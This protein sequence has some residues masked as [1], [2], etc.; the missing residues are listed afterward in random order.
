M[1][2]AYCRGSRKRPDGSAHKFDI[3]YNPQEARQY[4]AYDNVRD[5]ILKLTEDLPVAEMLCQRIM[6]LPMHMGLT[7]A[8]IDTVCELLI[9]FTN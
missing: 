8:D 6:S 3:A 1:A 4:F 7:K 9:R 5:G 2:G